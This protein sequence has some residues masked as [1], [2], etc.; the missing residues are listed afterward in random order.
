M[1]EQP[2]KNNYLAL[3]IIGITFLPA[4]MGMLA[5]GLATEKTAFFVSGLALGVIGL[6]FLP[7]GIVLYR[8]NKQ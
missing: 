8:R 6:V 2:T 5:I 7:V 4:G 1:K 3:L